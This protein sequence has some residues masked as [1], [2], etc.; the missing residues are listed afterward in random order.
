MRPLAPAPAARLRSGFTLIELLTVI[1]I[2]G[3]LAAIIIPTVGKV[4]ASARAAQGVSNLRQVANGLVLYAASNKDMLPYAFEN[5]VTDYGIRLSG[6][7]QDRT[8]VYSG[9]NLRAAILTDPMAS[10]EGGSM[11]FSVHPVL[12]PNKGH[13]TPARISSLTRP[14]EL[15]LVMDGTQDPGS[16]NA[17]ASAKNVTGITLRYATGGD[18]EAPVPEGLNADTAAGHIRWRMIENTAA[19]FGFSDGHVEILKIGQLKNR[20]IWAD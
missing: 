8:E 18:V 17:G 4:R 1:A 9:T 14:S 12:M 6:F 16:K 2:I 7:L 3:I 20:H 11:H 13:G 10:L 5:G 19:K 15:V